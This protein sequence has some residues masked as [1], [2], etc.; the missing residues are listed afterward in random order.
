M[1][2]AKQ[3]ASVDSDLIREC[4]K[5]D[6]ESWAQLIRRY[7]RLI[8]S[9]AR[10]ICPEDAA[11]IFQ[12]VCLELYERLADLRDEAALPKWLITVTRRKCYALIRTRKYSE[13]L[14]GD[15]GTVD[16]EINQIEKQH[17]I[18]LSL[19]QLPEK[20][21]K[22]IRLLY[23]E[24]LSYAQVAMRLQIPVSSIGP[25]RARCLAKLKRMLE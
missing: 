21:R 9:V 16:A 3:P 22:L 2:S 15:W 11:D 7:E 19:S 6:A 12:Q 20:C 25:T 5:G 4:L 8:F 13:P 17:A 18:E 23:H 10:V 24:E 1:L 14:T